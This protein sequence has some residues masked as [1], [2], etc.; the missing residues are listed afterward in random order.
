MISYQDLLN[1]DVKYLSNKSEDLKNLLDLGSD[2]PKRANYANELRLIIDP[3]MPA[4]DQDQVIRL[5]AR[6]RRRILG[7]RRD[8]SL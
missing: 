4:I 2:L 3:C 6:A 5:S 7:L 8:D 1:C